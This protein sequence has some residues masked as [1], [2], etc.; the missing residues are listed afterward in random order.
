LIDFFCCCCF[1]VLF[2]YKISMTKVVLA[3]LLLVCVSF[4]EEAATPKYSSFEC[5]SYDKDHP[6]DLTMRNCILR[7]V[8]LASENGQPTMLFY[9]RE[10]QETP[11]LTADKKEGKGRIVEIAPRMYA[12]VKVVYEPIPEKL[13]PV[14]QTAV[15]MSAQSNNIVQFLFDTFFG[16][17]WMLMKTGDIPK[18]KTVVSDPDAITIVEVGRANEFTRVLQG[19]V[20]LN[21]PTPLRKLKGVLFSRVVAGP[22]GHLMLTSARGLR[23]NSPVLREDVELYRTFFRTVAMINDEDFDPSRVLIAQRFN[24]KRITNTDDIFTAV[25]TIGNGQVAFLS[26]LSIKSQVDMV[27][28][29]GIYIATHSDDI[30]YM[31]FLRPGMHFVEIMPYGVQSDIAKNLAELCGLKY[32][33]WQ[34]PDR[35]R[36][37]FDEKILDKYPLTDEQKKKIIEAEKYEKTLPSGARPYWESQNT[38]VDAEAIKEILRNIIPPELQKSAA[39][40]AKAE[41]T[42]L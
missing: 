41:K 17:Y 27:A 8:V 11:L 9:A 26:Q 35:S 28:G 7:D 33:M 1:V 40:D 31:L 42:E 4:A 29:S 16:V 5:E 12:S 32:T 15:L 24:T 23:K 25:N 18:G 19:S 13:T 36:A 14:K 38:K 22:A 34:N 30:A 39:A 3:L 20:T 37:Q 10:G 2:V 21:A 6:E